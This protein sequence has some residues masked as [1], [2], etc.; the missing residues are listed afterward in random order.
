MTPSDP[1]MLTRPP[2]PNLKWGD[3]LIVSGSLQINSSLGIEKYL[4][5]SGTETVVRVSVKSIRDV[6]NRVSNE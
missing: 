5:T 2:R 6:V 4:S 3:D 1:W